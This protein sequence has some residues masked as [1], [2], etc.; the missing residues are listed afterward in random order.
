MLIYR[1]V[2]SLRGLVLTALVAGGAWLLFGHQI[3]DQIKKANDRSAGAG[4]FDQRMVSARRF[5]PIAAELRK[6]E[7]PRAPMVT[8]VM[9]PDSVEFVLRSRGALR[10][11]RWRG[12]GPLQAFEPGASAD[13]VYQRP[14]WPLSKLDVRAPGRI[15]R[16]ITRR[17]GGDFLLSIGDV[18]RSGDGGRILWVMR[19]IVGERGIAYAARPDGTRIGAYNPSLPGLGAR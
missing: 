14:T 10:G 3:V 18:G 2:R 12:D 16:S 5:A 13:P 1:L 17:E 4:P 8:V 7:G 11:W 6:R 9:R 19:G 15:S